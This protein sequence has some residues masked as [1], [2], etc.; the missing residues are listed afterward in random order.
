MRR[1]GAVDQLPAGRRER[2]DAPPPVRGGSPARDQADGYEA[3]DA[4]RRRAGGDHRVRRELPRGP[5]ERVAGPAERSEHVELPVPEP[6]LVID[7]GELVEQHGREAVQAPERALG[8]DVEVR[9]LAPPGLLNAPDVVDL[10]DS[11]FV[12]AI[13]SSVEA[14]WRWMLVTAVA[15]IAWGSNYVVTRQL[16]PVDAPLHG[17]AIRAL[18]AGLLLLL[19]TRELPRGS[20]WWRS[21]VLGV[22]NVGAFFV[23]IYLAAQLLP[24]SIAATLMASSAGVML[25]LAWPLLGD[26]P[27]WH[28]IAGAAI[29]VTGVCVMLLSDVGAVRLGGVLASLG[30]M[31]MSS[32][33]FLLTKRWSPDTGV[34]PLTAWQLVAGGLLLLPFALVLEPTPAVGLPTALAF[35]YVAVV[36]TALAF[37]AWFAG[38]KRLPA[39]TVGL[40]GLL[41]PV[42]GVV[43]GTLL[44]SEPFGPRQVVGMLLVFVGVTLGRPRNSLEHRTDVDRPPPDDARHRRRAARSTLRARKGSRA[45]TAWLGDDGRLLPGELQT[46]RFAGPTLKLRPDGTPD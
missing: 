11:S 26:R 24:S 28:A 42:T 5:L 1:E 18:P 44:A 3:V 37:V 22:L 43:L 39:G 34:L 33:G 10:M 25:L 21:A 23:L 13:F 31:T 9:P 19:A 7:D 16:L 36:C 15:P 32:V 40:I 4:L 35:V 8:G 45:L 17:A 2:H 46:A 12:E 14:T 30:A 27:A 41:N 20:W 29:G 6:V 38:L